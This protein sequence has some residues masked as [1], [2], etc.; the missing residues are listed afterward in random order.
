MAGRPYKSFL[1][2][3]RE[4]VSSPEFSCFLAALYNKAYPSLQKGILPT[5]SELGLLSYPP[6]TLDKLP[7][8]SNYLAPEEV[9]S[10]ELVKINYDNGNRTEN[11][12]EEWEYHPHLCGAQ[13]KLS[14]ESWFGV[15]GT[16]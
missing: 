7:D 2:R 1:K 5:Q 8:E 13:Y 10:F 14:G 9:V 3:D 6:H 12:L 11:V 15:N 4:F 16:L